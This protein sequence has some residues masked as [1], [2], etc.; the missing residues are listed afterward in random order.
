MSWLLGGG[1]RPQDPET[2]EA[3]EPRGPPPALPTRPHKDCVPHVGGQAPSAAPARVPLPPLPSGSP[4]GLGSAPPPLPPA[5]SHP[6]G[7]HPQTHGE[8]E[9]DLQG[10]DGVEVAGQLP[11]DTHGVEGQAPPHVRQ[12]LLTLV[13]ESLN[14]HHEVLAESSLHHDHMFENQAEEK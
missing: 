7:L 5:P 6:R 13:F 3:A 4:E 11:G 8:S 2:P 12:I 1:G 14:F 9:P 10:L